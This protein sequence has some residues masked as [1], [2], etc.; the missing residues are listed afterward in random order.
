VYAECH[1]LPVH[2]IDLLSIGTVR[3]SSS[4]S[5]TPGTDMSPSIIAAINTLYNGSV[6]K[7][8]KVCLLHV[9]NVCGILIVFNSYT[10]LVCEVPAYFLFFIL[11][12]PV[13]AFFPFL[14]SLSPLHDRSVLDKP[15]IPFSLISAYI[16][17]LFLQS[18][19]CATRIFCVV[20]LIT[21]SLVRNFTTSQVLACLTAFHL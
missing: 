21:I 15:S 10:V 14:F 7:I 13:L 11:L 3:T 8:T 6:A 1:H 16:I 18:F 2:L 9:A 5:V 20:L 17:L 19:C 12:H 4:L